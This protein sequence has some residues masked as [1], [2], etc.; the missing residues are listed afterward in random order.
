[1]CVGMV[2]VLGRLCGIYSNICNDRQYCHSER[3]E[4]NRHVPVMLLL[5]YVKK[6]YPLFGVPEL[7]DGIA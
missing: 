2:C 1:M 5:D 6:F 4:R 7:G 3:L